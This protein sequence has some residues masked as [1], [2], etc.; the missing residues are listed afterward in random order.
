MNAL[1][2][3]VNPTNLA[4]YVTYIPFLAKT[5]SNCILMLATQSN[6]PAL[7]PGPEREFGLYPICLASLTST[8]AIRSILPCSNHTSPL[9]C[10]NARD[11]YT[12]F[13]GNGNTDCEIRSGSIF[14]V[15]ISLP[16][17]GVMSPSSYQQ[18]AI[19]VTDDNEAQ[20]FKNGEA[21]PFLTYKYDSALPFSY[22]GVT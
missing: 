13:G 21:T 2:S 9:S 5:D 3:F 16:I 17:S 7:G 6:A 1:S 22:F 11:P 14:P 20:M 19:G 12:V 15:D 8:H 18:Y 10:A 4:G